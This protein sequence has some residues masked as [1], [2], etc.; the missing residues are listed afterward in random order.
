MQQLRGDVELS[1]VPRKDHLQ[2]REDS[3]AHLQSLMIICSPAHLGDTDGIS[4]RQT[5]VMM[6]PAAREHTP[7]TQMVPLGTPHTTIWDVRETFA[8]M[9]RV[10]VYR[11][12][13]SFVHKQR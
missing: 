9:M 1:R 3:L 12:I 7:D 13:P 5:P 10:V 6:R 4:M 2:R 8:S 11:K